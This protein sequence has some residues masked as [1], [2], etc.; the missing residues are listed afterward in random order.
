MLDKYKIFNNKSPNKTYVSPRFSNEN[1]LTGKIIHSR[2]ISKVFDVKDYHFYEYLKTEKH[3]V[4]YVTDSEREEVILSVQESDNKVVGFT[5]Q[6]WMKKSGNPKGE[7]FYFTKDSFKKMMDFLRSIEFIDFDKKSHFQIKDEDISENRNKFILGFNSKG[8]KDKIEELA[9]FI[10]EGNIT[11]SDLKKALK[12]EREKTLEEFKKLLEEKK[13]FINYE[14]LHKDNI[15]GS[16]E[17]AVWHHF[18]KTNNWILGLNI[19]IRFIREFIDESDIGITNTNGKGSPKVDQIG[20][21]DYT[22][23]I[24]FKTP[25]TYIF[26]STKQSTARTNTWSFSNSFI[27]GISQCLAQKFDWDKTHNNKDIIDQEMQI[28]DQTKVRTID[29]KSI[30]IIGSKFREISE[31]SKNPDIILKRDTF[32]RF[33]RNNRNIEIITFDELYERAYFIVHN[34]KA[35][36]LKIKN[37]KDVKTEDLPF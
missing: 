1:P 8:E 34:E 11:E 28:I 14:S 16:G 6:R 20:L 9:K 32:E 31:D 24:E 26:T 12:R 3:V 19:D 23:L 18:L 33:I 13:Y 29:P 30:F 27:D 7:S 37:V 21:T 5:I 35:P 22:V 15:K 4:L 25:N 2:K 17:E 36:M 10:K